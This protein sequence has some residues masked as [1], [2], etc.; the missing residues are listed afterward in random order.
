MTLVFLMEVNLSQ[1]LLKFS[2][3][4]YKQK[5][6]IVGEI[7][8]VPNSSQRA[9]TESYDNLINKINTENKSLV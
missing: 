2:Q 1:Y 4:L 7:Y 5:H 6:L 3:K 9:F 8:R